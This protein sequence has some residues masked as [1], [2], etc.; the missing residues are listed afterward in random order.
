M[1]I[2]GVTITPSEYRLN[3][4]DKA[5]VLN[6]RWVVGFKVADTDM[7]HDYPEDAPHYEW[8]NLYF[9]AYDIEEGDAK[10]AYA[11]FIAGMKHLIECYKLDH[12]TQT[13]REHSKDPFCPEIYGNCLTDNGF[14]KFCEKFHPI[15]LYGQPLGKLIDTLQTAQYLYYS[16]LK[17]LSYAYGGNLGEAFVTYGDMIDFLDNPP[18]LLLGELPPDNY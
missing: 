9:T 11:Y 12:E 10:A 2:V 16:S 17:L 8:A 15:P 7:D 14:V 6:T 5:N 1:D 18:K 4:F 3:D 13:I